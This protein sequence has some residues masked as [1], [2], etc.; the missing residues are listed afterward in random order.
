MDNY[1]AICCETRKERFFKSCLFCLKSACLKCLESYIVTCITPNCMFC[2]KYWNTI[3]LYDTFSKKFID[4]DLKNKTEIFLFNEENAKIPDTQ[5]L[6]EPFL[7]TIQLQKDIEIENSKLKI[8]KTEL[9]LQQNEYVDFNKFFL[10]EKTKESLQEKSHILFQNIQNIQKT[11]ADQQDKIQNLKKNLKTNKQILSTEYVED[12]EEKHHFSFSCLK[13][14]CKGF[15]TTHLYRCGVCKLVVCEN[16]HCIKNENHECNIDDVK[17]VESILYDSKPCPKCYFMIF[18]ISGCDQM[19]CV[20]CQTTFSWNT[21][22]IKKDINHNPHYF[23]YM[24]RTGNDQNNNVA[25]MLNNIVDNNENQGNNEEINRDGL[26]CNL[27]YVDRKPTAYIIQYI[28]KKFSD[29]GER[30]I[31]FNLVELLLHIENVV[32]PKLSQK[33]NELDPLKLDRLKYILNMK[34]KNEF[35]KILYTRHINKILG[36]EKCDIFE[37]FIEIANNLLESCLEDSKKTDEF[38]IEMKSLREHV[39]SSFEKLHERFRGT[40]FV[41]SHDFSR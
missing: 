40:L 38:L 12:K 23:E 28:K 29:K 2:G 8:I 13:P 18:K 9:Q 17:S 6:V 15:V 7:K 5:S 1:C 34:N 26:F 11:I 10:Q 21:L 27:N 3:F 14:N 41:I 33:Q 30:K 39:N 4:K 20:K 31:V 19:W 24:I 16:C 22:E 37:C 25:N 32:I 35:C 36:K